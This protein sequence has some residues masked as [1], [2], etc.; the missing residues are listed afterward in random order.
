MEP[1]RIKELLERYWQAETTVQEEAE[2]KEY[3]KEYVKENEELNDDEAIPFF[4]YVEEETN[5]VL[6]DDF[7]EQLQS[8]IL[9]KGR[10]VRFIYPLLKIAAVLL[11]AFSVIYF[12]VPNRK[13]QT[14]AFNE[15]DTFDD[16]QQAYLETRRALLLISNHLNAGKDYIDEVGKLNKAEE[17]I[18][19]K[20]N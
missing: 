1:G 2:L 3:F 19:S 9:K 5:V 13:P 11:I 20:T 15:A 12:F 16:P 14:I 17:L 8:T 18:H 6:P 7:N 4:K 10:P